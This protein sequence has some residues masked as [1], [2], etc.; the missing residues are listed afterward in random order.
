MAR[1][2]RIIAQD[3]MPLRWCAR[4][5]WVVYLLLDDVVAEVRKR[6]EERSVYIGVE[7][8]GEDLVCL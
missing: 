4:E 7:D 2:L 8:N 6:E 5:G 3:A 1:A